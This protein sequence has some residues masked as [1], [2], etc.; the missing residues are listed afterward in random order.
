MR[1]VHNTGTKGFVELGTSS[2][3]ALVSLRKSRIPSE[4]FLFWPADH[5]S[6]LPNKPT[7]TLLSTHSTPYSQA[8]MDGRPFFTWRTHVNKLFFVFVMTAL[9][10]VQCYICATTVIHGLNASMSLASEV[11]A[12]KR[13]DR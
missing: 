6:N 9:L 12:T 10:F 3:A 8:P 4:R 1:S 5:K 13:L 2:Q 11:Q 7:R